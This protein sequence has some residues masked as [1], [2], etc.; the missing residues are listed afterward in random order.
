MDKATTHRQSNAKYADAH[1]SPEMRILHASV[2]LNGITLWIMHGFYPEI[3]ILFPKFYY[4]TFEKLNFLTFWGPSLFD[5]T[6]LK[7]TALIPWLY[8]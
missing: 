3:W 4:F 5:F 6:K 7:E 2:L 1:N 8:T